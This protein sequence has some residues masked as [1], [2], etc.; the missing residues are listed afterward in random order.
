MT[1]EEFVT[2]K[3]NTE[4][5]NTL[6]QKAKETYEEEQILAKQSFL[7]KQQLAIVNCKGDTTEA[8]KI[9]AEEMIKMRMISDMLKHNMLDLNSD[10]NRLF[11]QKYN[12][13]D[14]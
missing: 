4:L 6:F 13:V 5:G 12:I 1:F 7:N 10:I 3:R 2:A 8:D 9:W 11:S 14:R